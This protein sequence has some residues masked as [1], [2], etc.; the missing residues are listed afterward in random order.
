MSDDL[1]M[2][3]WE[4]VLK[5]YNAGIVAVYAESEADAWDE[6]YEKDSTAWW[7]IQGKPTPPEEF[8]A[9]GSKSERLKQWLESEDMAAVP[10]AKQPREVRDTEAFVL[11]GGA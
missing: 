8:E 5:N 4:N 9:T 10:N 3:V 1:S 2:Y 7:S 6:L 11:W